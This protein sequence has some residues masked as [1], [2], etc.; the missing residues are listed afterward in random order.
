MDILYFAPIRLF[1]KGHGNIATVHQYIKRLRSLGH[2]VHYVLLNEGRQSGKDLFLSQKFVDTLDVIQNEEEIVRDADGY[3]VFDTRYFEGLGEKIHALCLRYRISIV[4]CTYIFHSKILEYI[5]DNIIKIIDTHDKMTDRHLF[6]RAHAIKDEFFSCTRDDEARYLSRADIIWARRDEE[7]KF[8]NEITGSFKAM[9]VSHFDNPCFFPEKRTRTHRVGFLASDNEVNH[10]MVKNVIDVFLRKMKKEPA[11]IRLII[12]G[13]VRKMFEADEAYP[14][15]QDL[16]VELVGGVPETE[17]FYRSLDVVIVPIMFGTGINVKMIEAMSFG[18]PVLSTRC[19]IK[20]IQSDSFWHTADSLE[21]LIDRLWMLWENDSE[22]A[23]L[24]HL[25]R[26]CFQGFFEKNVRAF[27]SCFGH[28]QLNVPEKEQCCGCGICVPFC[29]VSALTM[30]MNDKGFFRAER[31][32][33]CVDCGLCDTICPVKTAAPRVSSV[34]HDVVFGPYLEV[35]AARSMDEKV[36]FVS[37]T[38]GFIRTFIF[39]N[40]HKFDGVVALVEGDNPFSADVR[41]LTSVENSLKSIAKSKYISVEVSHMAEILKNMSGHFIVIGLPCHI[42]ALKNIEKKLKCTFFSIDLFC[43]GIFSKKFMEHYISIRGGLP[44]AVDFRDKTYGWH[45]FSLTLAYNEERNSVKASEDIFFFAQMNKVFTQEA[46]L[47]C[48]YCRAGCADV[49]VGDFW[50]EKFKDVNDGMNLVIARSQQAKDLVES[51]PSIEIRHCSMED[52]YASQ[53]WFVQAYRRCEGNELSLDFQQRMSFRQALNAEIY[54]D[55]EKISNLRSFKTILR[56]YALMEEPA[57]SEKNGG[58]YLIV[59]PDDGCGSFG[60]Q[61]MLLSL[62]AS[63][64]K[65]RPEANVGIFL[66]HREKEDGFLL[67]RGIDVRHYGSD[68]NQGTVKRFASVAAEYD[69]VLFIGADILDGG[70]GVGNSLEYFA[71]MKEAHRIGIPVDIMGCSFN[72]ENIPV[73]IEG[74]RE[75]SSFARI[76]VRDI[77]SMKRLEAAGCHNLIQVADLAFSFNEEEYPHLPETTNILQSMDNLRAHGK[78]LVGIHVTASKKKGY[79]SFFSRL[80]ES[81]KNFSDTTFILLPHDTRVYTEKYSDRE[82]HQ[83]LGVYF[84]K[85][86]IPFLD[87][88]TAAMDEASV[89][90]IAAHLDLVITSRMHLAIAAM[91]RNIPAITFAYQGKFEGVYRLFAFERNLMFDSESFT[92]E[93]LT[94]AI[95][96]LMTHD[97]TEMMKR[98]NREISLLSARNFD[99]MGVLYTG[100]SKKCIA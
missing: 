7:T 74:I 67:N 91:S 58:A 27:D 75:I 44:T 24:A 92:P 22:L 23:S 56:R 79:L 84:T 53:P 100:E 40:L 19:G 17:D 31:Q 43:G 3:Y 63:L 65:R 83:R 99:F 95:E 35:Y 73:I 70:C 66:R 39:D 21:E 4:I 14:F 32:E 29:P 28:W 59:P 72:N 87:V 47:A 54:G 48:T 68:G 15:S 69:H 94:S 51:S 80:I 96:F 61:A 86:G 50:G 76:H 71:M 34:Y 6:L 57:S 60:D 45:E 2:R 1:P 11:D 64:Q 62:L 46:C 8:F 37:S 41:L 77:V 16:P 89:K 26:E 82:L 12:G 33:L 97:H 13:G 9:T 88:T 10:T 49:Q 30:T 55:L 78:R 5:P 38:A 18:M 42:A 81:L 36:R 20:G 25:S 85:Y 90:R 93:E 98:C 52:V